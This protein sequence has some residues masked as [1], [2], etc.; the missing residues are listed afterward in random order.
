VTD[1]ECTRSGYDSTGRYHVRSCDGA[2]A[3]PNGARKMPDSG[4]LRA[5]ND[6][7]ECDCTA[8]IAESVSNEAQPQWVCN[9]CGQDRYG[10]PNEVSTWHVGKCGI[11]GETKPVTE[12]RDFGGYQDM[13]A[14]NPFPAILY[15]MMDSAADI[16]ALGNEQTH[17][18][19]QEEYA[20]K[21]ADAFNVPFSVQSWTFEA[22][23]EGEVEH[24]HDLIED[25]REE[26]VEMARARH[27][28][29]FV[30]YG[31]TAYG[32]DAETR[33]RNALEELADCGVYLTSGPIE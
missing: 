22:L 7:C 12:P 30:S 19:L 10:I 28:R 26:I 18:D 29:G 3:P 31:S 25:H 8:Q 16:D 24:L 9:D 2:P 21:M 13:A 23:I 1:S 20:D 4:S 17:G 27:K 14:D 15:E 33:L 6:S 11:C 32:W 5:Q